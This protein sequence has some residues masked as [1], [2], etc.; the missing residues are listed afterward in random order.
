MNEYQVT[1]KGLLQSLEAVDRDID[2]EEDAKKRSAAKHSE[3]LKGMEAT[4]TEI[5]R[6]LSEMRDNSGE[7]ANIDFDGAEGGRVAVGDLDAPTNWALITDDPTPPRPVSAE[8]AD[9]ADD[10]EPCDEDGEPLGLPKT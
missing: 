7:Q 4:R 1:E 8:D 3:R 9:P 2:A 5:L 10:G 6:Q